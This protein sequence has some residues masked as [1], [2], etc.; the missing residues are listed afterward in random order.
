MSLLFCEVRNDILRFQKWSMQ[1]TDHELMLAREAQFIFGPVATRV[2]K[3]AWFRV[4]G[5]RTAEGSIL[6]PHDTVSR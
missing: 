2:G 6:Y 3:G 1:P 4:V 5:M